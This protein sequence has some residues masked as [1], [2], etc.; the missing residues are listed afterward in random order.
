MNNINAL[1]NDLH[2]IPI[3]FQETIQNALNS[4]QN[5]LPPTIQPVQGSS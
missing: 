1:N 4:V 5:L 3:V 2:T